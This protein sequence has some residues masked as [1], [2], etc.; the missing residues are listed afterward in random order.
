MAFRF[1]LVGFVAAL[2]FDMPKGIEIDVE[3]WAH[4]GRAWWLA[5][6]SEIEARHGIALAGIG[7]PLPDPAPI[8]EPEAPPPSA[9]DAFATVIEDVVSA[10]VEDGNVDVIAEPDASSQLVAGVDD[11]DFG[12]DYAD[13]LNRWA[14]GLSMPAEPVSLVVEASVIESDQTIETLVASISGVAGSAFA[15]PLDSVHDDWGLERSMVSTMEHSDVPESSDS[16]ANAEPR[17]AKAFQL[18]GQALQAW[19]ALVQPAP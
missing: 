15:A 17:L 4:S 9:D 14:D 7:D 12:P 3:S 8:D 19:L 6:A 5:R 13:A 16:S 1:L 10:F 18:T 11:A 2:G